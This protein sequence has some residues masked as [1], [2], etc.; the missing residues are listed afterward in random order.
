MK[1]LSWQPFLHLVKADQPVHCLIDLV[2][3]AKWGRST[4]AKMLTSWPCSG[5]KKSEPTN[6]QTKFKFLVKIINSLS[7]MRTLCK[8]VSWLTIDL[9][10]KP[11]ATPTK[12][13]NGPQ[14]MTQSMVVILEDGKRLAFNRWGKALAFCAKLWEGGLVR[15]T[16]LELKFSNLLS[17][18]FKDSLLST[19]SIRRVPMS[20]VLARR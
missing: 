3:S 19:K 6:F 7:L 10:L 11:M 14:S 20:W 5:A 12:K 1:K 17:K 8:W 9:E 2:R 15:D 4:G 16:L 18:R 13:V